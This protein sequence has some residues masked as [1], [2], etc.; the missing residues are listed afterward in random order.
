MLQSIIKDVKVWF[1]IKSLETGTEAG[2]VEE[3]CV[4][5][6]P[7]WLAQADFLYNPC[8][9]VRCGTATVG[10]GPSHNN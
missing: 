7:L 6:Y 2:T 9:P 5:A 8:L 4:Q 3:R 1:Q 10:C